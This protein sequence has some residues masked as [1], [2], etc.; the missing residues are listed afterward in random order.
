MQPTTPAIS[1]ATPTHGDVSLID[2]LMVLLQRW[3]LLVLVPVLVGAAG[4]GVSYLI[5]PQFTATVTFLPPQGGSSSLSNALNSLGALASLAGGSAGGGKT[6]ADTYVSLLQSRTVAD[7]MIDKFKLQELYKREFRFETRE[8]LRSRSRIS[9]GKKDGLITIEVDDASPD[10]AAQIANQYVVELK[11]LTSTMAL[12]DAQRRRAFFENQLQ[13]TKAR[14]TA[15]QQALESSGFNPGALRS[16][17]RAAAEEYGRIKAELTTTEVRLQS[18]RSRLADG[19]P[20]L[21]QLSATAAALRSQ[22]RT[23]EQRSEPLQ[24]QDYISKY[25]E[26]KYQETLFEQLGR[27]F[28][29]A[30][31]EESLD[32]TVLQIIDPAQVP[33][34]KSKPKRAFIAA[35]AA[36]ISLLLLCLWI[37]GRHIWRS[38]PR[39]AALAG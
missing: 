20:E 19:A 35:S 11:E 23:L 7:R 15:A 5:P 31:L 17:P 2:L 37:A 28:E 1:T 34:W 18:L 29:T 3:Q 16:E 9:L 39:K 21:N 4:L 13:L 27:Q 38:V 22:L 30:R 25:R 8:V 32:N 33:E 26:F 12:T 24:N 36:V 14:L 10:R 6:S